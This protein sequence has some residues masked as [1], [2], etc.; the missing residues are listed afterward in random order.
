MGPQRCTGTENP[1]WWGRVWIF[2]GTTHYL[3]V[4]GNLRLVNKTHMQHIFRHKLDNG[5]S[6]FLN[7]GML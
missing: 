2:S 3:S 1:G 6:I 7:I 4:T 5:G